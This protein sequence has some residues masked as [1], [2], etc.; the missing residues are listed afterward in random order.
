MNEHD[1]ARAF[2]HAIAIRP[3]LEQLHVYGHDIIVTADGEEY[4]A[5]D[6]VLPAVLI[7]VK[8]EALSGSATVSR[9]TV[10]ISV[11]SQ[12]DDETSASHSARV[13]IVKEAMAS[14]G[15]LSLGFAVVPSVRLLGRPALVDNAP[16]VEHRAFKTPLTYRAGLATA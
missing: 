16:E 14:V 10:E 6:L 15:M 8:G 7:T 4:P 1:A 12:A 13:Q 3:G 2:A 5:G 9:A 11:E